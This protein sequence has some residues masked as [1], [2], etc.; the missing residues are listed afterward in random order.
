MWDL[1]RPGLEPVFPALAGGFLTTAP[2]GKPHAAGMFMQ[3][4]VFELS[5]LNS[6]WYLSSSGITRS[7][8]FVFHNGYNTLPATYQ[9]SNFSTSLPK[10]VILYFIIV[11]ISGVKL[12]L[13]V[14][15]ILHLLL[16]NFIEHLFA[17]WLLLYL[18]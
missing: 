15:L 10:L 7:H 16:T 17:S 13:M 5:V 14:V 12:Y 2:P 8:G 6:F 4:Y 3:K 18:L 9:D 11:I 1:P